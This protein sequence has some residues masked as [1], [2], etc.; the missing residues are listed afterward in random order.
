MGEEVM[1]G[2]N[3]LITLCTVYNEFS[4]N[5]H[6]LELFLWELYHQFRMNSLIA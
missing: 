5:D 2:I 1:S 3:F 6:W 4:A